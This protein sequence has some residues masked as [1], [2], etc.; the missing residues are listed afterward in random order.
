MKN[1]LG[2]EICCENCVFSRADSPATPFKLGDCYF[3][4]RPCKNKEKFKPSEKAMEAR[5]VEIQSENQA[6]LDCLTAHHILHPYVQKAMDSLN[7]LADEREKLISRKDV[8]DL[9]DYQR[10]NVCARNTD[11]LGDFTVYTIK[12]W[13]PRFCF[14]VFLYKKNKLIFLASYPE[15]SDSNLYW[16]NIIDTIYARILDN[17][18]SEREGEDGK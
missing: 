7:A 17:L 3:V 11:Q 13:T 16:D 8:S 2:I 10:H 18:K 4:A 1:E 5:I 9:I 12:Q 15:E 14:Y 6:L